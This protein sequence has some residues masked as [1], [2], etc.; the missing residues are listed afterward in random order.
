MTEAG[1]LMDESVTKF[2]SET[3]ATPKKITKKE[4]LGNF[5]IDELHSLLQKAI[6]SEN[7][8]RASILRDEIQKRKKS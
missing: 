5:S 1:I 8:E 7:Y 6:E 4:D 3:K 2:S